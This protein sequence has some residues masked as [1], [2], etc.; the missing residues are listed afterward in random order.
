MILKRFFRNNIKGWF[1]NQLDKNVKALEQGDHNRIP[2]IF[3]V[4]AEDHTGSKLI[5]AQALVRVLNELDYD[6]IIKTDRQMRQT[7]SIEWTIDW[8]KKRIN[9]FFTSEMSVA[10]RRAIVIFSSFNPNGFIREKAV[11]MMKDYENTLPFIFLRQND[12]VREV[13]QT[14]TFAF[15]EKMQKLNKGELLLA[16]PYAEKL[17]WSSRGSHGEYTRLFLETLTSNEHRDELMAGLSDSNVRTRRICINALFESLNDNIDMAIKHLKHEPDPFLR[18]MLFSKIEESGTKAESVARSMLQDKF[19]ANRRAALEYIYETD[20]DDIL[21]IV[22]TLLLDRSTSVR[23]LARKILQVKTDNFDF[24]SYYIKALETNTVAGIAGL[25]ET[26][27][28]SDT[29]YIEKYIRDSRTGI[30]RAAL[31]SLMKLD[32]EKYKAIVL[33]MLKDIRPGVVKIAHLLILKYRILEYDR[34]KE[35]FAYTPYEITKMKC[36]A[37]LF[38]ASKWDRLIYMLAA[39]TCDSEKVRQLAYQEIETWL[40][41]FNRSSLPLTSD[42]KEKIEQ[43]I[44]NLGVLLPESTQREIHFVLKQG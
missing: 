23:T 32:P 3:C 22:N 26:G 21:N 29:E 4:F 17:K 8:S 34:I 7:T 25:G 43:L 19:S 24:P 6:G 39:I 30:V 10:E 41:N 33:D 31:V 36:A 11:I 5:A 35:I 12:W 40:L 27:R 1:S 38:T 13:R 42:K 20:P 28:A 37:L 44:R 14:A 2:W 18:R 9:D 15:C 16:L